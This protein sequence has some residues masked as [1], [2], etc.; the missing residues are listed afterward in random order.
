MKLIFL[1]E[2]GPLR[3]AAEGKIGRNEYA[4]TQLASMVFLEQPAGV[5]FSYSTDR[6]LLGDFNDL[7]ASLDNVK[8]IRKF[9][10]K[11]PYQKDNSIYLASESYGGDIR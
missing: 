11:F 8:I 2:M 9:F 1:S 5:G 10:E 6:S 3:P 4:W 7:R